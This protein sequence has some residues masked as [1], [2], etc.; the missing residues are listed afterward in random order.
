LD[1]GFLK[2]ALKQRK[3]DGPITAELVQAFITSIGKLPILE[4]STLHRVYYYDAKPMTG[5]VTGPLGASMDFTKTDVYKISTQQHQAF[6][7]L[8]Y[9]AMRYGE[10][11]YNGWYV[12]PRAVRALKP[13]QEIRAEH[14]A[15]NV[16]QKG[17]DMRIGLDIATLALKHQ[18]GSIVLVTGDSDLV[19]AM[20]LARREGCKLIL[21]PLGG[22]LKEPMYEHADLVIEDKSWIAYPEVAAALPAAIV[23]RTETA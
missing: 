3:E 20:K 19:P 21:I 14:L 8:P 1:G 6:T 22:S 7:R 13:G 12:K 9:F 17:V 4:G 18:V 16:Q 23:D 15:P 11:S 10:L 5:K 2:F